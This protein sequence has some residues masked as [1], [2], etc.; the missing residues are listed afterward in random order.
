MQNNI[1]NTEK[2]G[3][4]NNGRARAIQA[5]N[6]KAEE[7]IKQIMASQLTDEVKQAKVEEIRIKRDQ[8]LDTL[9]DSRILW[10]KP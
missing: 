2:L 5:I 4:L 7:D 1:M 10:G 8:D 9:A 6:Q 3:F